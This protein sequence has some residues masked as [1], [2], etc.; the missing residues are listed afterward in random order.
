MFARLKHFRAVATRYDKTKQNNQ[1]LIV[2]RVDRKNKEISIRGVKFDSVTWEYEALEGVND[3]ID[4]YDIASEERG[5]AGSKTTYKGK[6]GAESIEITIDLYGSKKGQAR[7]ITYTVLDIDNDPVTFTKKSPRT[8]TDE[9]KVAIPS[10]FDLKRGI[11]PFDDLMSGTD[12]DHVSQSG[13][14]DT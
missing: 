3:C 4:H 6:Q 12:C 13:E 11:V 10:D 14:S 9:E 2:W 8:F 5:T 7:D 1:L